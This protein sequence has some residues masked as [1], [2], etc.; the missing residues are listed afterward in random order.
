MILTMLK[1]F[2]E[3]G[4]S[5]QFCLHKLADL[6][7]IGDLRY[8]RVFS[9]QLHLPDIPIELHVYS[10]Q[11]IAIWRA[12]PSESLSINKCIGRY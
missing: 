8:S 7:V 9:G 2:I 6:F 10:I 12:F 3:L 1:A 4:R 5:R 11:L